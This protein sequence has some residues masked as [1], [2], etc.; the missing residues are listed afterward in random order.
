MYPDGVGRH[1]WLGPSEA[2]EE[3]AGRED[4]ETKG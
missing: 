1:G 3:G 4:G 2:G